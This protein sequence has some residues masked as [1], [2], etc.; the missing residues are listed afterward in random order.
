MTLRPLAFNK[1]VT[2][3]GTAERIYDGNLKVAWLRIQALAANGLDSVFVGDSTVDKTLKNGIDL[4]ITFPDYAAANTAG[5]YPFLEMGSV[6]NHANLISLKDIWIDVD[7]S[8]DGVTVLA[9]VPVED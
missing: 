6:N 7:V 1:T 4:I 5:T 3:A 9:L 2:T 8:L